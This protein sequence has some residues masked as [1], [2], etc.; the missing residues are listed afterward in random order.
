M[1]LTFECKYRSIIMSC[2]IWGIHY[3]PST[4]HF[5]IAGTNFFKNFADIDFVV[6]FF[7]FF[8]LGALRIITTI[9]DAAAMLQ[10]S[11]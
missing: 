10:V 5:D 1:N 6:F 3:L 9:T 2:L 7:F 4:S 8:F 11:I